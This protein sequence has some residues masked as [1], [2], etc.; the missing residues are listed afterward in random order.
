MIERLAIPAWQTGATSLEAWTTALTAG[1]ETPVVVERES[2]QGSWVILAAVRIR[3]F[4]VLLGAD[5]EAINFEV[6]NPERDL[7]RL[8]AVASSI[9][10]ELHEDDGD[11]E[12]DLD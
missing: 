1:F 6:N 7:P 2:P 8:E 10:W 3:G 5:V 11:D 4:A 12:D 9:G